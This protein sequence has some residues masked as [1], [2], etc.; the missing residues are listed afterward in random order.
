MEKTVL[1]AAMVLLG[2]CMLAVI[3]RLVKGPQTTDRI[4]SVNALNTLITAL[5]C[6]LSRYLKAD[7]LI[8]VALIYALLGFVVNT[9]LTRSLAA[10]KRRK[11]AQ[12]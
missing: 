2:L 4:L 12:K 8:D 5:I 10:G 9:L 6:L 1:T 3:A 7:Y 11:G